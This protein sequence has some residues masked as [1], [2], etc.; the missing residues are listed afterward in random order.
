[1]PGPVDRA[2]TALLTSRA[3]MPVK[4]A[5]RDLWWSLRGFWIRP[6]PLPRS[7]RS[8]LFV[9]KGNIC[10]SPFAARY[11]AR[12]LADAGAEGIRCVSAGIAVSRE[13]ISPAAAVAAA[14]AFG[15]DL[16]TH[17]AT[18]LTPAL[19]EAADLIVV[20]EV[21]HVQTLTRQYPRAADR[22][23]LLP[24]FGADRSRRGGF[25]RF[26]IADP[27]GRPVEVFNACYGHIAEAVSALL[28]R[29]GAIRS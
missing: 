3:V 27:Y 18:Q 16:E 8:L 29:V 22:I 23:V 13:R 7:P 4:H 11:A 5:V 25:A 26:N 20:T 17:Q 2:L 12:L 21:S 1:M 15:V 9:C 24:L 28:R 10:R 14:R 6:R 19:V